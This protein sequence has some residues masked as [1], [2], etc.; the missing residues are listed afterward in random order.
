MIH[1]PLAVCS[2]LFAFGCSIST[3]KAFVYVF[4]CSF[5]FLWLVV[6][7]F[8]LLIAQLALLK[9]FASFVLVHL[10]GWVGCRCFC[11][12]DCS[13]KHSFSVCQ[14]FCLFVNH[15]LAGVHV[16]VL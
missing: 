10:L 5:A 12:F 3:P 15:S 8:V 2:Y 4:A 11:T 7:V 16:F 6:Y 1:H 14:D 13:N 9:C